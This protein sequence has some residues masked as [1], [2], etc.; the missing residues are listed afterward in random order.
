MGAEIRRLL[1]SGIEPAEVAALAV[2]AI[3]EDEL[4]VFTH[5]EWF[6]EIENRFAAIQA[7]MRKAEARERM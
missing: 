1:D 3:R 6:F 5:P 4:Y 7:A 2:N